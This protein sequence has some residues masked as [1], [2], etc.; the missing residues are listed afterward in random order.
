MTSTTTK[1]LQ[2]E[3]ILIQSLHLI[4]FDLVLGLDQYISPG[5]QY[6]H[7]CEQHKAYTANL[8]MNY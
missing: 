4:N 3:L 8:L 1:S 6:Y 2:G 5:I 7:A